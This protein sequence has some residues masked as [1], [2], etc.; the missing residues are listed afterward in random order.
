MISLI[1]VYD[2]IAYLYIFIQEFDNKHKFILT[3]NSY[4]K[5]GGIYVVIINIILLDAE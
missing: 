2:I 3:F 4:Q 1:I 5:I